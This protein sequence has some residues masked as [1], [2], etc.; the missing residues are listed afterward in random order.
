MAKLNGTGTGV[1]GKAKTTMATC[2]PL[3][4]AAA[5]RV[6]V[7]N[8]DGKD[9]EG[10]MMKNMMTKTMGQDGSNTNNDEDNHKMT[11][12]DKNSHHKIMTGTEC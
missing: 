6:E 8:W 10:A 4:W 3:P 9:R 5:C 7:S 12:D 11:M 1:D 2:T